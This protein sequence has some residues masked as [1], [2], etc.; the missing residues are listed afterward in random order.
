MFKQAR[1]TVNEEDLKKA[2]QLVILPRA[3]IKDQQDQSDEQP[4]PP[5]PPPPPQDQQQ[6]EEEKEEDEEEEEQDNEDQ[7][8]QEDEV[9]RPAS[10]LYSWNIMEMHT[11]SSHE[12]ESPRTTQILYINY[13]I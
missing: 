7:D 8:E 3:E 1:E 9:I 5:P 10:W 4:P 13:N 11:I 2:V 12:L 6:E